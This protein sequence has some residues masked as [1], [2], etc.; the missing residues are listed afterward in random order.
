MNPGTVEQDSNRETSARASFATGNC[1]L[2]RLQRQGG[3][4]VKVDAYSASVKENAYSESVKVDA[5]PASV[6]ENAYRGNQGDAFVSEVIADD[7][8][9]F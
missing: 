7:L 3:R 5:Y 6:K 8:K 2:G 1:L 4:V 9:V